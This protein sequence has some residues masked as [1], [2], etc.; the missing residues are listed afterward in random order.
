ALRE[1]QRAYDVL[2][3]SLDEQVA[4]SAELGTLSELLSALPGELADAL[5]G[6]IENSGSDAGGGG[7][8]ASS[9]IDDIYNDVLG[10]N[11]DSE[12][13][14]YWESTGLRG[15]ALRD[16][17]EYSAWVDGSHY[18]GLARVPFD[19]Y[20]AEL[21]KDETVLNRH[22]A[23]AWRQQQLMPT[24]AALP[25]P[26]LPPMQF[27]SLSNQPAAPAINIEP[28]LRK[29]DALTQEVAQLRG[30]RSS[31]AKKAADQRGEQLREQQK[32][33][34]HAKTRVPTV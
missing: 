25:M 18:S 27:P 16:A 13:A 17:I 24:P 20:I 12:G 7:S 31:D 10:R 23:E 33:N 1:Q 9:Y 26:N 29:I 6:I 5:S 30:E 22:D 34:R 3:R 21:H 28:L 11:A 19:G 32:A 15:D 4:A 8:G 14:A 2:M